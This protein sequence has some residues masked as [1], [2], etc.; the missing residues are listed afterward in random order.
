MLSQL[1]RYAHIRKVTIT[2]ATCRTEL[3]FTLTGSVKRGD[4]EAGCREARTHLDVQSPDTDHAVAEVVRL[5]HKGCFLE[6]LVSQPVP[7]RSSL[8]LNGSTYVDDQ[9]H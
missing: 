5:A 3:D 7:M 1:A 2:A 4:V 6:Q 9:P 8:T